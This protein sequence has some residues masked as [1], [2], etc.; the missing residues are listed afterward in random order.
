MSCLE[1][2]FSIL[3]CAHYQYIVQVIVMK[4]ILVKNQ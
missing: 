3:L 1:L 4:E 2:I